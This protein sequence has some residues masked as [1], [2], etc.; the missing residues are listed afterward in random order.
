[1]TLFY[2][3]LE[4]SKEKDSDDESVDDENESGKGDSYD[5]DEPLKMVLCV[6]TDL[7]MSAGIIIVLIMTR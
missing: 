1:M 3:I 2:N 6:R 7:K 5:W 4:N